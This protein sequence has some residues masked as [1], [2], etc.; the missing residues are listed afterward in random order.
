MAAAIKVTGGTFHSF[1]NTVLRRYASLLGFANAFTIL[2]RGDSEDAINLIRSNMGLDQKG[3]P[4]PAQ[5]DNYAEII[6][7]AANK[8]TSTVAEVLDSNS[9]PHLFSELDDLIRTR[10]ILSV[11]IN[12]SVACSTTMTC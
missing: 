9:F 10:R 5:T 8:T 12:V 2:D 6:S 3:A 4:L 1:A 7:L 11:S